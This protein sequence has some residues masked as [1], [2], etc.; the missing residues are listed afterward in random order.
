M[1]KIILVAA[2]LVL[3][4]LSV[5]AVTQLPPKD[6]ATPIVTAAGSPPG[7][8]APSVPTQQAVAVKEVE[9][10]AAPSHAT[11]Q[12]IW[13]L[14]VSLT[15]QYLKK[16]PWFGLLKDSNS[17][18]FKAGVGF[19]AAVLTAAGIHF[20][21]SGNIFEGGGASITVTGISFNALKDVAWQWAS[22]Q[23]WYRAVVKEPKEITLVASTLQSTDTKPLPP[24]AKG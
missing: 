10:P 13:A 17:S 12:A 6:Q 21:V 19:A 4:L 7:P 2:V 9:S 14:M 24:A 3:P 11:D 18:R 22:Q 15:M 23:G 5:S 20:A 8:V 16:A 1:K